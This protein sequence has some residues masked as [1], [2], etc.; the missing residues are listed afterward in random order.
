MRSM[1]RPFSFCLRFESR[2]RDN[3][4]N[5]LRINRSSSI[6]ASSTPNTEYDSDRH[7]GHWTLV[8][9]CSPFLGRPGDKYERLSSRSAGLTVASLFMMQPRQNILAHSHILNTVSL[10]H[11]GS[12]QMPHLLSTTSPLRYLSNCLWC[13]TLMCSRGPNGSS[14]VGTMAG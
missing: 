1:Y 7:D 5:W 11:T 8:T 2:M 6:R 14:F 3:C 4:G 13:N 9:I 12:S 10:W